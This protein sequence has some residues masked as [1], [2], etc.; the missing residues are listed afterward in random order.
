MHREDNI[1][2][3]ENFVAS[4]VKEK[5]QQFD[6]EAADAREQQGIAQVGLGTRPMSD[7]PG[8][9][10]EEDEVKTEKISTATRVL[11]D[12]SD[13]YQPKEFPT[14]EVRVDNA[15]RFSNIN[16]ST[17]LD[18]L[19]ANRDGLEKQGIIKMPLIDIYR[20]PD[21]TLDIDGLQ[22]RI[23]DK[24][25]LRPPEGSLKD[26]QYGAELQKLGEPTDEDRLDIESVLDPPT[27]TDVEIGL[28]SRPVGP[29]DVGDPLG[30]G[31]AIVRAFFQ[32]ENDTSITDA[33]GNFSQDALETALK[34]AVPNQYQQALTLGLINVE[35]G[36]SGPIRERRFTY[37]GARNYSSA[38]AARMAAAGL[39]EGATGDEIFN[40][41]YANRN[42]NGD[43]ASGDGSRF[44][45]RG[46]IQ[47]TGRA[48]YQAVQDRLAAK[49]INIDLVENPDLALDN[50]YALPITLA[51]LEMNGVNGQ[52]ASSFST[53]TLNNLIN[54]R[55]DATVAEER[56][57]NVVE[58][59][60]AA[61][62]DEKAREMELRN[63]YQA[64]RTVQT[65]VDG[66]IGVNSY[67]AIQRWA[68]ER[69]LTVPEV[70]EITKTY[71][72]G[73]RAG[74]P[75]QSFS[76]EDKIKL[77]IFVNENT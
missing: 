65:V 66:D 37:D 15:P 24:L 61:N 32:E 3:F 22:N 54:A 30:E 19:S 48:N 39:E 21:P 26:I 44:A 53:K 51:Y 2:D 60:E 38:W 28:M 4:I 18:I 27:T 75:Y 56:W 8:L 52:T 46:M 73:P 59:L 63:E 69:D 12:M 35:V 77:A 33:D 67:A 55:A 11:S 34:N 58:A 16:R 7:R 25:D 43:F 31:D 49:G 71:R 64:Q 72:S 17:V 40:A 6:E 13:Y 29:R 23:L 41:V 45:G 68:S 36:N 42:G 62:E 70:T 14:Q 76:D 47:L 20:Q 1:M 5:F 50:R 10:K 57:T 9:A 74:Q